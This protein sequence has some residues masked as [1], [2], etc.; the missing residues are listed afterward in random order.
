MK[1]WNP[2]EA[3]AAVGVIT[4]FLIVGVIQGHLV[5]GVILGAIVGVGTYAT[6]VTLDSRKAHAHQQLTPP[7]EGR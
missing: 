6:M 1:L 3:M 2:S 4:V 7:C 5:A